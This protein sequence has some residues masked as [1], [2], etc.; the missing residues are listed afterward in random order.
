M[1]CGGGMAGAADEI[2]GAVGG[3][4]CGPDTPSGGRL[5]D[6]RVHFA[7]GWAPPTVR[8]PFPVR[9]RVG[10]PTMFGG[11]RHGTCQGFHAGTTCR[12]CCPGH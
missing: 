4:C 6:L 3:G 12:S 1:S 9:M 8:S 5:D 10:L 11:C 2:D 7:S